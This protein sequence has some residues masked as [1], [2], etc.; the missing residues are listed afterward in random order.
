MT[1]AGFVG[2][3]KG[4]VVFDLDAMAPLD[5]G[6]EI[7]PRDEESDDPDPVVTQHWRDALEVPSSSSASSSSAPA[8]PMAV[9]NHL[10]QVVSVSSL[11]QV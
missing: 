11:W 2:S 4:D 10:N 1:R 8:L 5:D 7:E 3:D 9:K 6:D